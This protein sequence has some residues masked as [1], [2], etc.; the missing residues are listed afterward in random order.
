MRV[1]TDTLSVVGDLASSA[2]SS[3]G[4]FFFQVVSAKNAMAKAAWATSSRTMRKLYRPRQKRL[5][6]ATPTRAVEAVIKTRTP[7]A[8][9]AKMNLQ[10]RMALMQA[11]EL[12]GKPA[13]APSTMQKSD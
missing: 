8:P 2:V 9:N 7:A 3:C 4:N 1:V 12:A 11:T 5:L 6:W 13:V 10:H